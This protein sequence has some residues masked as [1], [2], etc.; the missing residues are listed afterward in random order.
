MARTPGIGEVIRVTVQYLDGQQPD[1]IATLN[2]SYAMGGTARLTVHYRRVAGRA[3]I[4][5]PPVPSERARRF[6][7]ELRALGFDRLEDMP[8]LPWRSGE[9]WLVERA[10]GAFGRDVV[11]SPGEAAGV[12]AQIVALTRGTLPEAVRPIYS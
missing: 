6:V 3:L 11:L 7:T 4:L 10:A 12:Y 9:L 2:L 1:Q 5:T 8:D